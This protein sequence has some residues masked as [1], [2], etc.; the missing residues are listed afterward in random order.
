MSDRVA[1]E[2]PRLPCRWLGVAKARPCGRRG[3]TFQPDGAPL[4][5]VLWMRSRT[6]LRLATETE[7]DYIKRIGIIA[8]S[9]RQAAFDQYGGKHPRIVLHFSESRTEAIVNCTV[10]W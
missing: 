8:E 1:V 4:K 7:A 3:I 9:L 2:S 10:V 5:K 6:V